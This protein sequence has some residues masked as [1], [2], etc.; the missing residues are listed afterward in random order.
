MS[1]ILQLKSKLAQETLRDEE[2]KLRQKIEANYRTNTFE[3]F[4]QGFHVTNGAFGLKP[5]HDGMEAA[6]GNPNY[7]LEEIKKV[8]I[9][10]KLWY[11][12][13]PQRW[14]AGLAKRNKAIKENLQLERQLELEEDKAWVS[15]SA[16]SIQ[17]PMIRTLFKLLYWFRNVTGIKGCQSRN[18]FK[19]LKLQR[20]QNTK[21]K[22]R[23]N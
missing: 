15:N 22:L 14:E 7:S 23:M 13:W 6:T 20:F 17:E 9:D 10:G 2:E 11:K 18:G 5:V 1:L 16:V 3:G 12:H 19:I 8:K 4:T 21:H